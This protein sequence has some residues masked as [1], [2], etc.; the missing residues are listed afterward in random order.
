MGGTCCL[1]ESRA[2]G[3]YAAPQDVIASHFTIRN[4]KIRKW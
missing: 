3:T 2:G 1:D 4:V